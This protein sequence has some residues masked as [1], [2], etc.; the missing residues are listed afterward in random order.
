M[1]E[2][3]R[4]LKKQLLGIFCALQTSHVLHIL[5]NASLHINQLLIVSI[6]KLV[7]FVK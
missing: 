4:A 3:W 1:W 7:Q 6:T 5:M 2:V